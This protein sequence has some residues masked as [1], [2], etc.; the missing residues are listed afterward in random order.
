[1]RQIIF[2]REPDA[3]KGC[4]HGARLMAGIPLGVLFG[5]FNA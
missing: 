5:L 2:G 4:S 3:S 1:M